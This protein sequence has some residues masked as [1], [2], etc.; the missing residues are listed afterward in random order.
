[1]LIGSAVHDGERI[2]VEGLQKVPPGAKAAAKEKAPATA[3]LQL[4]GLDHPGASAA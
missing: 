1:L 4:S 3:T 2:I